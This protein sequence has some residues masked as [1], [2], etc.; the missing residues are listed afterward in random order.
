M[1][2]VAHKLPYVFWRMFAILREKVTQRNLQNILYNIKYV[3]AKQ[4]QTI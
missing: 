1:L 3:D 4:A 2:S